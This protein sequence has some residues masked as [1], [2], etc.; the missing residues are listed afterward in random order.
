[1]M[2]LPLYPE[3][4][5]PRPPAEVEVETLELVVYPDRRRVF[6]HVVV[7]PFYERPNLLLTARDAEGTV[8]A[9]LSVIETM[10]HDMEFTMHLRR[11]GD[12]AGNY[13]LSVEL[14]YETR[15]PPQSRAETTFVVP[16]APAAP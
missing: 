15:N 14:Y 2:D 13:T 1:M 11:K 9:E 7:T 8:A 3:G 5:V 6:L 16:E 12:T 4:Y 10:H